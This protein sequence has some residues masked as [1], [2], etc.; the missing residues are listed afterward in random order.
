MCAPACACVCLCVQEAYAFP[1]WCI[2]VR[3]VCV[4]L[5]PVFFFP[6]SWVFPPPPPWIYNSY[7]ILFF[8]LFFAFKS[9]VLE[10]AV[11]LGK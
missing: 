1:S 2:Y 3:H 10:V 7:G 5:I 8:P 4:L 6:C 11:S 9:P